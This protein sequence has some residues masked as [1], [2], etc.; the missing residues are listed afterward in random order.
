VHA[1]QK[2]LALAKV[3]YEDAHKAHALAAKN[4]DAHTVSFLEG[5]IWEVVS[6]SSLTSMFSILPQQRILP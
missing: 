2:T 4:N 6:G 3:Y 5:C 1:F